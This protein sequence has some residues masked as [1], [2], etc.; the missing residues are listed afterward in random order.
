M[1]IG[2]VFPGVRAGIV[3]ADL[4]FLPRGEEGELVVSAT[5]SGARIL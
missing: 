1:A 3:D 4:K 5:A 2:T